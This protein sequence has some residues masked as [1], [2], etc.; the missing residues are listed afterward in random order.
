MMATTIF[1]QM[2]PTW[3]ASG[4]WSIRAPFSVNSTTTYTC[5][6]IRSFADMR[7]DNADIQALVYTPVGISDGVVIDKT[8]GTTFNLEQE[9][10]RGINIITL[11]DTQGGY[12]L[13]PDNYITAYPSSTNMNFKQIVLSCSLGALPVNLDMTTVKAAVA[14]EVQNVFGVKPTVNVHALAL[15]TTP[16]Y[17]DALASEKARKAAIQ[18]VNS[19]TNQ[20]AKLQ[21]QVTLLQQQNKTLRD[22]CQANNLITST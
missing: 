15:S 18:I 13:I 5:I 19:Q 8:T 2:T 16:T 9:E 11:A 22:L 20:L 21:D 17:A 4:T 14:N 7:R 10:I 3:M 12:F 6:A 1:P